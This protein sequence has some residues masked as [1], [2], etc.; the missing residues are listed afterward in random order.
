M[1]KPVT[2]S[3]VFSSG[4]K[5]AD[6]RFRNLNLKIRRAFHKGTTQ[7]D[8][9]IEASIQSNE[10]NFEPLADYFISDWIYKLECMV[11]VFFNILDRADTIEERI[12]DLLGAPLRN[13]YTKAQIEVR[14]EIQKR[15]IELKKTFDLVQEG[16]AL[17]GNSRKLFFKAFCAGRELAL[18]TDFIRRRVTEDEILESVKHLIYST[19]LK[20]GSGRRGYIAEWEVKGGKWCAEY[21]EKKPWISKSQLTQELYNWL[22]ED[23]QSYLFPPNFEA[24][25][26]G[27]TRMERRGLIIP[28]K[29]VIKP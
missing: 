26:K 12:Q 7:T 17:Y 2:L 14:A 9:L 24:I 21:I 27:V 4:D 5:S 19:Y 23:K 11:Y 3:D 20:V 8:G 13:D 18:E 15:T 16:K 29:R 25:K 22:Y 1:S 28:N 6:E 10:G